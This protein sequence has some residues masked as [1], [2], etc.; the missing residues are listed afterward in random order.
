MNDIERPTSSDPHP[1]GMTDDRTPEQLAA[2]G[3]A[4]FAHDAV[5]ASYPAGTDPR[6]AI[7]DAMSV[8]MER[9]D[10]TNALPWWQ[11]QRWW[12]CGPFGIA[13]AKLPMREFNNLILPPAVTGVVPALPN[14]DREA[15]YI[16]KNRADAIVFGLRLARPALYEVTV[17][18]EPIFDD[19]HPSETSFRVPVATVRR[20][21]QPTQ[22][23]LERAAQFLLRP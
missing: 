7:R 14:S 18:T 1:L 21:E 8:F 5:F 6:L 23:E 15:V 2:D 3:D 16:T 9:T 4:P 10:G 17:S 12:H 11:L 20:I 22:G 19:T 13:K